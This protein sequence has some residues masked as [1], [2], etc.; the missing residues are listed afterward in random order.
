[1]EGGTRLVVDIGNSRM[2]AGLFRHGRLTRTST[3]PL[4]DVAAIGAFVA[5]D[6]P[7]VV[8]V[9]SV[10]SPDPA[11]ANALH[12]WAPVVEVNGA[13]EGPI[14]SAYRTRDTLG[15]DRWA[16][17]VAASLLFPGRPTL[18]ISLGTCLTYDLVS[19]DGEHLGGIIS[20]GFRMRARAMG[21]FTA[22]L[23]V[24][25]PPDTPALLGTDT[26]ACLASGT[27][28]G[29]LAELSHTIS[30]FRQKQTGLAVVLTGGDALRFARALESG[31]F[32]H[33]FLTLLGLHALSLPARL[34]SGT[35]SGPGR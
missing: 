32:A 16:N 34:A 6:R 12:A 7:E 27:H 14:R 1:M 28:H 31:I 15:V 30:G 11:F 5:S 3:M 20:P 4:G 35:S 18:A 10:A 22:R 26:E 17:A 33:P 19:A 23:M 29:L 25:D 24:V 2:K 8:V 9:G 21:E 13:S